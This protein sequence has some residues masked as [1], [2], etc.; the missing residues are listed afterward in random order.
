MLLLHKVEPPSP[1]E[2]DGDRFANGQRAIDL[3]EHVPLFLP[4]GKHARRIDPARVAGL[5][6]A[7]RKEHGLIEQNFESAFNG[8]AGDNLRGGLR[9]VAVLGIELFGHD[10]SPKE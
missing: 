9:L 5:P 4:A 7:F 8:F 1:V 2:P 6:A 10:G 3:M